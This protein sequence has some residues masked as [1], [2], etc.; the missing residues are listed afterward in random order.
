MTSTWAGWIESVV[1]RFNNDEQR[2]HHHD[3]NDNVKVKVEI[4]HVSLAELGPNIINEATSKTGLFDGFITPPTVMGS[5]VE[6]DGW[7]DLRPYIESTV[8]ATTDWSDIFLSYRQWISQYQNK[9]LMYPLDGDLMSLFYRRDILEEFGLS[10]PRTWDEYNAVAAATHGKFSARTNKTLVGSCVGRVQGCAGAYYANLVLSSMTQ[11]DGYSQGHLFDTTTMKP[12]LGDALIQTLEWLEEQVQYGPSDQ[13]TKCVDLQDE[14]MNNGECVMT[15]NWGN[16][17]KVYLNDGSVFTAQ[18]GSEDDNDGSSNSA[19]GQAKMGVA[20][21]P[22]STH[23]LDRTTM[24][25]VPCTQDLC[26]FAKYYDDIGYVN[27]APYLAFGGWY[28]S[29]Q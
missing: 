26:K 14:Y 9:I 5:I 8:E 7:A 13:F 23:V 18:D 4:V 22:G 1:E 10:V 27:H 24:K 15:Y 11:L 2:H 17:F 20:P 6:E 3:R 28:V 25:L 12:L 19:R 29:R 21:T 16:T